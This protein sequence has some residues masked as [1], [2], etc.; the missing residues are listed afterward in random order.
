MRKKKRRIRPER[1][2]ILLLLPLTGFLVWESIREREALPQA[3]AIP[4]NPYDDGKY[5]Y[6]QQFILYDDE[7]YGSV[8]GIDVSEHNK[9]IDWSKVAKQDISFAYLRIGYR[10]YGEGLIHPDQCF[11][12]N[13]R[14]AS[15]HDISI[16]IY[17]FSQAI[18]EEEARQEAQ[19]VIENLKHKNVDL[20]IVYDLEQ[21]VE[22]ARMAS[23]T[24]EEKTRNAQV[25]CETILEAGYQ[26]MIYLNLDWAYNS[27][28][29]D[30]LSEYPLWFAQYDHDYPQL[31]NGFAVWQY[32]DR[33][34]I[35]GIE[36]EVDLNLRYLK[37]NRN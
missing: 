5:Y 33:G 17:F 23:L 14:G 20:E 18:S 7:N 32:S 35:E 36:N 30:I 11:E 31:V 9:T 2:L 24:K 16:G 10:G 27:Y 12:D 19:F 25:F 26:P 15:K 6:E 4:H 21:P 34:M 8:K 3:E 29:L 28:D 37:K 1:I 13:Y 22:D